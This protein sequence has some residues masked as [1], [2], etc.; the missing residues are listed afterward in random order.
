MEPDIY[1]IENHDEALNVWHQAEVFNRSVLHLDAHH[2]M[3]W[4]D[5]VEKLNIGNYLCHALQSNCAQEVVWVVPPDEGWSHRRTRRLLKRQLLKLVRKYPGSNSIISESRS[6]V[7]VELIDRS[8]IACPLS[9][10]PHRDG[11][12]LL[13]IDV[14]YLLVPLSYKPWIWPE[15][16]VDHL[17]SQGVQYD[18]ATVCLSVRGGYVPL[19][20]R[21]LGKEVVACL[22]GETLSKGALHRRRAI[23]DLIDG[24]LQKADEHAKQSLVYDSNDAATLYCCS[25]IALAAERTDEATEFYLRT[26]EIDPGY[27]TTF[28][29]VARHYYRKNRDLAFQEWTRFLKL[30]PKDAT[31]NYGLGIIF[32]EQRRLRAAETHLRR[33]IEIDSTLADALFSLARVLAAMGRIDEAMKY[34]KQTIHLSLTGGRFLSAP[35]AT[36]RHGVQVNPVSYALLGKLYMQR[37]DNIDASAAYNMAVA[38]GYERLMLHANL[39]RVNLG[40][41]S[42]AQAVRHLREGIRISPKEVAS[43][44]RRMFRWGSVKLSSRKDIPAFLLT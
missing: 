37:G 4:S 43:L 27:K 28:D 38:A 20:W 25:R 36:K 24:N 23:L 31:A 7:S 12:V 33:A 6:Q 9:S 44:I 1:L 18:I 5:Q 39:M 29:F 35:V 17:N 41:R 32:M 21:H 11:H 34:C 14:D 15:E 8:V 26:I 42:Y 10:I 30:N 16:L 40:S 13:D 3:R 19:L 22:A 2:D